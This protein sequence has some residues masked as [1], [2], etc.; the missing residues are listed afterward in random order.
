MDEI[1]LPCKPIC[2]SKTNTTGFTQSARLS[3]PPELIDMIIHQLD[4]ETLLVCALVCRSWVPA[5]RRLLP[6]FAVTLSPFSEDTS[7]M[8]A[9]SLCMI[10][11]AVNHL[12]LVN[13]DVFNESISRLSNIKRLTFYHC[14]A[15]FDTLTFSPFMKNLE[16]LQL[17]GVIFDC[18]EVFVL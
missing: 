1:S 7:V 8:L 12:E 11:A 5:S 4:E 10:T 2:R 14:G 9:S 18:V 6:P 13:F 16:S 15:H 3:L 17:T